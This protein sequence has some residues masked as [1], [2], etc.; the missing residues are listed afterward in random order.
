VIRHA[1][2]IISGL[3]LVNPKTRVASDPAKSKLFAIG[4]ARL[5]LIALS[6]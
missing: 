5:A 2:R 1:A 4:F 3:K 6:R